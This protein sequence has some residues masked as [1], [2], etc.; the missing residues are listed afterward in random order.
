[1]CP[2]SPGERSLAKPIPAAAAMLL[3]ANTMALAITSGH[4]SLALTAVTAPIVWSGT[5][6]EI[7]TWRATRAALSRGRPAPAGRMSL[8][9]SWP[10]AMFLHQHR[11]LRLHQRRRHLQRPARVLLRRR[12]RALRQ[13]RLHLQPRRPRLVLR[14]RPRRLHLLLPQHR[15]LR[16]LRHHRLRRLHPHPH[17]RRRFN[18]SPAL[19]SRLA[20]K[21]A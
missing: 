6:R 17:P 20:V 4:I 11:H 15:P 5:L 16:R 2:A 12:R 19:A 9:P 10:R 13:A 21:T 8:S 7:S 1:M 3:S 18:T 14:P